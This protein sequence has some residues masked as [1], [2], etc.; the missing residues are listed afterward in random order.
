MIL[1]FIYYSRKVGEPAIVPALCFF[2]V[3][4]DG[5]VRGAC[6]FFDYLEMV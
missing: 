6:V 3:L 2:A 4:A 1:V 5:G